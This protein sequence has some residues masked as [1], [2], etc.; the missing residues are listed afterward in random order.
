MNCKALIWK[1]GILKQCCYDKKE[2]C[3]FH[4]QYNLEWLNSDI[5]TVCKRC[6]KGFKKNGNLR[7]DNCNQKSIKPKNNQCKFLT[8]NHKQCSNQSQN[9]TEFC[10][11]HIPYVEN[12]VNPDGRN[13]CDDCGKPHN[14]S[15]NKCQE[16]QNHR[17]KHQSEKLK[18]NHRNQQDILDDIIK[19]NPIKNN[20]EIVKEPKSHMGKLRRKLL[21]LKDKSDKQI[22]EENKKYL[23]R[24]NQTDYKYLLINKCDEEIIKNL[25]IDME[26]VETKEQENIWEY[27]KTYVSSFSGKIAFRQLKYLVK[28]K[29]TNKIIG[30][31][32]LSSDAFAVNQ[33]DDYIGWS[34]QD[35]ESKINNQSKINYLMNLTTVVGVQPFAFNCNIGKL[36]T[37]LCFSQQIQDDFYK[38]YNHH[39]AVIC[40]YGL[41]GKAIQYERLPYLKYIG[42]TSGYGASV[43]PIKLYEEMIDT[44]KKNG[45][46][47]EIK[48]YNNQSSSK[49]RKLQFMINYLDLETNYVYHGNQRGIYVGFVNEDAKQFIQNKKETFNVKQQSIKEITEWWKQRWG[50]QRYHKLNNENKIRQGL[51]LQTITRK[52]KVLKNVKKFYQKSQSE[53]SYKVPEEY[54]LEY[55][56]RI[57]PSYIAGFLDG[58]GSVWINKVNGGYVLGIS[59]SQTIPFLLDCI[60]KTYGGNIYVAK[61][62]TNKNHHKYQYTLRITGHECLPLLIDISPCIIS[63]FK[64][65]NLALEFLKFNNKVN[66]N[67]QKEELYKQMIFLNKDYKTNREKPYERINWN[68]IAGI[69]DAEG[70]NQTYG[71]TQIQ[72]SI[73]Q[74]NDEKLLENILKFMNIKGCV[75]L[76]GILSIGKASTKIFIEKVLDKLIVKHYQLEC[77]KKLLQLNPKKHKEEIENL[78]K[79]IK[80]DKHKDYLPL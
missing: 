17:S 49:M 64:Q 54:N 52:D 40:T 5:F 46:D 38:K 14:R 28:D 63:K 66:Y 43:F 11:L 4:K 65:I 20:E 60:Q 2:L 69:Y 37:S 23:N 36:L 75:S 73:A 21:K 39:I 80:E 35:K 56:N 16:C 9:N 42:L 59:F 48:K 41:Y 45:L 15:V 74:Q 29:T 68:Y 30:I 1:K 12:G 57:N 7:C 78:V 27:V 47:K 33:R 26:L 10:R 44:F 50:L 53:E 24:F 71:Y 77:T 18:E 62:R 58:D 31:V 72:Q 8:K 51:E 79:T 32:S 70:C 76:N 3:R 25:D 55:R 61:K 22:I 67:T 13:R 34:K 6:S 19:V